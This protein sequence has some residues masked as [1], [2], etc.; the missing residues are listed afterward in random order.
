LKDANYI[1]SGPTV[2]N[3]IINA[4]ENFYFSSCEKKIWL[5]APSPLLIVGLNLHHT[6][7]AVK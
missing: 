7:R 5:C 3:K 1:K 2:F 6:K 4:K